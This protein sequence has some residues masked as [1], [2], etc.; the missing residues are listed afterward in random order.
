MKVRTEFI[1]AGGDVMPI[2]IERLEPDIF[3]L[4]WVGDI[5]MDAIE[6]SHKQTTEEAEE[7]DVERYIH[8]ID[9]QRVGNLPRDIASARMIMLR[10]PKVI[11]VLMVNIPA[12]LTVLVRAVNSIT[13][14]VSLEIFDSV[15]AAKERAHVILG[16]TS[17]PKP[18]DTL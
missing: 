16:R 9:T 14:R 15:E 3:L 1:V 5:T 2:E 7:D 18:V 12:Y 4:H 17:E 13:P 8:I 11:A 6:Q 10:Y